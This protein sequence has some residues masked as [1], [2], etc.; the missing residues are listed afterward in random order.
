MTEKEPGLQR[1]DAQRNR[2]RVLDAAVEVFDVEGL[3]AQMDSVAQRAGVG[4]GTVYRHFP[5]KEDLVR[6]VISSVCERLV[7]SA[8]KAQAEP[9]PGQGF[10]SFF[11][12]MLE[13]QAEHRVLAEEM[14]TQVEPDV[15]T[16]RL[17]EQ[18]RGVVSSLLADAQAAGQIRADIGVTDVSM[19]LAGMAQAIRLAEG[20][21]TLAQ[22]YLQVLLDG[23][24]PQGSTPLPGVALGYDELDRLRARRDA[25]D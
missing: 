16:V 20:E 14:A 18:L 23:L 7:T 5:T 1:A 9:L 15:S 4:V 2:Q 21:P 3:G 8:Q 19:L 10:R 22:R 25:G 12:T 6:A 13:F 24:S 11:A 17:K